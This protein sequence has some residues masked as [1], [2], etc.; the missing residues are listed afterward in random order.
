MHPP[1][2]SRAHTS[3]LLPKRHLGRFS[4]STGFA[5]VPNTHTQTTPRQDICSNSPHPALLA[6][7]ALQLKRRSLP[8][9]ER[10]QF[11]PN[12]LFIAYF[13]RTG[14]IYTDILVTLF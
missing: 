8:V 6:V 12:G 14:F 9:L 5:R 13:T 2:V 11:R 7:M 3:L 10:I 1:M 4:W